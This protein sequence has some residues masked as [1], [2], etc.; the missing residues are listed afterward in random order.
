VSNLVALAVFDASVPEP[1][2]IALLA[3]ALFGTA[4]ARRRRPPRSR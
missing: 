2:G 4:L 3:I 1:T